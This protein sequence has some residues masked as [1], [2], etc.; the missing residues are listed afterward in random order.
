MKFLITREEILRI[1]ARE[2][3]NFNNCPLWV[4]VE[5]HTKPS[6][7]IKAEFKTKKKK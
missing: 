1:T 5:G 4:E 7:L 3:P 6:I 2:Y